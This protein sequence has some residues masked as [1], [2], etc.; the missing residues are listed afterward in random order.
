MIAF[1]R[2]VAFQDLRLDL[3]K[4]FQA[5]IT[6]AFFAISSSLYPMAV[7]A[8]DALLTSIGAGVLCV[9]ALLASL[10]PLNR[11][12]RTDLQ[13]GTL[14]LLHF[15]GHPMALY[16]LGKMAAHWITAGLPL[17]IVAPLI[18]LAFHLE[19]GFVFLEATLLPLTVILVLIG[20]I[21]AAFGARENA[22]A[23]LTALLAMPL[24]VPA[25]IFASAA[26]GMAQGGL[27][28]NTLT[29][30]LFLWAG[31]SIA[32]PLTPLLTAAI[33]KMQME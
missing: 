11:I 10:L 6:P 29:P 24:A 7:G 19:I 16:C 12:Y 1:L 18:A 32:L 14:D 21:C 3:K 30:L 15:S 25:L 28:E 2:A 26:L 8:D 17:M 31:L 23:T 20:Q 4:S 13:D 33:L 22:S 27:S 5:I 9:G